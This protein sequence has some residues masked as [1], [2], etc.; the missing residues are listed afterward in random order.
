M[1]SVHPCFRLLSKDCTVRRQTLSAAP[2][3]WIR[4]GGGPKPQ[5]FSCGRPSFLTERRQWRSRFVVAFCLSIGLMLSPLPLSRAQE[6]T[7]YHVAL[8]QRL[9][10]NDAK[11]QAKALKDEITNRGIQTCDAPPPYEEWFK[12]SCRVRSK[13]EVIYIIPQTGED[14]GLVL[15]V[16]AAEYP[17]VGNSPDHLITSSLTCSSRTSLLDCYKNQ[18]KNIAKAVEEYDKEKECHRG[19]KC[20]P[21]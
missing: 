13:C 8:F 15:R 14:L 7:S 5:W 4:W 6:R 21:Q 10:D 11:I 9:P 16:W 19:T 2:D 3:L 1:I 12:P 17:K 20:S 18:L